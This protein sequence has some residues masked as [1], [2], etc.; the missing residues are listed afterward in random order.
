MAEERSSSGPGGCLLW[1]VVVLVVLFIALPLV[2][3]FVSRT[4][5]G[6][7]QQNE[8]SR[9]EKERADRLAA[10][11]KETG[12]AEVLQRRIDQEG[13]G[14][15]R[16][17]TAD[18]SMVQ[19]WATADGI[20]WAHEAKMLTPN[21]AK[22]KAEEQGWVRLAWD[23][24]ETPSARQTWEFR[25]SRPEWEGG[26]ASL[27]VHAI[28]GEI[29]YAPPSMPRLDQK[30][31]KESWVQAAMAASPIQTVERIEYSQW[32]VTYFV[33]GPDKSG[34][35]VQAWLKLKQ[36]GTANPAD[37]VFAEPKYQEPVPEIMG[38]VYLDEGISRAKAIEL[39]E[40]AGLSSFGQPVLDWLPQPIWY[41]LSAK[42]AAGETVSV[43]VDW[44]SGAVTTAKAES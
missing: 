19:A 41:F 35:P 17:K 12:I 42:N 10:V 2:S 38:W 14:W 7:A 6:I 11:Q 16:G 39:V 33:I 23:K 22:A 30:E 27:S 36:P 32:R 3:G 34:R 25:G 31:W 13:I 37:Q 28:T 44:K 29:K 18:G 26:W 4:A 8:I 24:A 43:K 20:T 5:R 21:A 15:Y 1:I 9:Q 40:A